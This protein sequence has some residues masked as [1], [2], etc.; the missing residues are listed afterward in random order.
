MQSASGS[1][2]HTSCPAAL[3]QLHS[4]ACT[5]MCQ[6]GPAPPHAAQTRSNPLARFAPNIDL[7]SVANVDSSFDIDA[8]NKRDA[9]GT[10]YVSRR[11][12]EIAGFDV[13][14]VD[15]D[16]L[17]L[18]YNEA[19]IA[20]FWKGRPGELAARWTRFARI[21]VPWLSSVANAFLRGTLQR[22]QRD[23]ARRAVDNL[24][25]LGPTFVKL[26]QILSI[27]PDVLPPQIMEE[28]A[29]LQ[30]CGCCDEVP[31]ASMR[32]VRLSKRAAI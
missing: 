20:E 11:R 14:A 7:G 28:L 26:G 6:K 30:V 9:G 31:I 24:E 1:L 2:R 27:R 29:R 3:A 18:V 8:M 19:R 32:C 5:C 16:G 22:D 21:A 12:L 4:R 25:K 15:D 13:N 17:P 23:L 10:S